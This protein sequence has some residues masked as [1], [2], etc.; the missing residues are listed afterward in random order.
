M[1]QR[2]QLAQRTRSIEFFSISRSNSS[3]PEFLL[4]PPCSG[5]SWGGARGSG[6][7]A[8]GGGGGGGRG[9]GGGVCNLNCNLNR[10]SNFTSVGV[11]R[12]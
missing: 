11:G 8:A 2:C 4:A 9:H 12:G 10:F 3:E 6:A 7:A 1:G 5:S